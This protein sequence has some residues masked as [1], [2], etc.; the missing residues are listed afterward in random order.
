MQAE[1]LL[2]Q[3]LEIERKQRKLLE[4]HYNDAIPID[5]LAF[6]QKL[7]DGELARDNRQLKEL[8]IDLGNVARLTEMAA[9]L[10]EKSVAAYCSAPEH[11]RRMFNQIL[12]DRIDVLLNENNDHHVQAVFAP[13]FDEILIATLKHVVEQQKDQRAGNA[14]GPAISGG[15]SRILAD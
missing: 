8:T 14:K 10:A 12:F 9:N 5:M 6:K 1:V 15:T 11:I 3:K 13:P 7:L 4:A 2:S